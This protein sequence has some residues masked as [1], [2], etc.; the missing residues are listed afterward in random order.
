MTKPTDIGKNRT[1][2][3]A[4]PIDARRL[5]TGAQIDA[6]MP[7]D[8]YLLE[9]ERLRFAREAPPVGSVP[10][11]GN[12]KGVVKTALEGLKG[13]KAT[14]LLDK[15][16]E[17]IAFERTGTRL[18]EALLA[19]LEAASVHEGGPR[20]AEVEK[21]RDDERQHF[22]LLRDC[23]LQLGGDPTAMTPSADVIAVASLGWVQV[24]ADPRTTLTQ[25]L[26]IM[27][28]AE[29]ADNDG[30]SLLIEL[31]Q[32]MGQDE[33]ASRFRTALQEEDEHLMKVR[34]WVSAAL[35]GQAGVAPT[36]EQPGTRA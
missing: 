29:L 35:V 34:A 8:G 22:A 36:P 7:T 30:W 15:L 2:I 1:G 20:R 24:L 16:G 14:V 26:D 12:V 6:A 10:P 11:P 13:H 25:C 17:R 27:L 18:Y 32:G 21:I 19:K 4:S 28:T 3:A 31:V 9:T 23:M 33:I 5:E